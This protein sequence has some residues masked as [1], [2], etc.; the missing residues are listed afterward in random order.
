MMKISFQYI[1]YGHSLEPKANAAVLRIS[2]ILA[3][4]GNFVKER[5]RVF[6]LSWFTWGFLSAA[7]SVSTYRKR[8]MWAW[9]A[10]WI[11]LIYEIRDGWIDH[12]GG[13]T[14]WIPMVV[15][16]ALIL[17]LLISPQFSTLLVSKTLSIN[18]EN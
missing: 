2:A 11:M 5:L 6:G 3:D 8:E 7:I 12:V 10:F 16:A 15:A 13:T 9:Y 14:G 1:F 18:A 4:L 17:T